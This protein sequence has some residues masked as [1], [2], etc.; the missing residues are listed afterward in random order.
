MNLASCRRQQGGMSILWRSTKHSDLEVVEFCQRECSLHCHLRLCC[1]LSFHHTIYLFVPPSFSFLHAVA[2]FSHNI[3][4][5]TL[6]AV[7][8]FLNQSS[9][10]R[11]TCLISMKAIKIK[12]GK[13]LTM[14][15]P[16][17][18]TNSTTIVC[19]WM[20]IVHCVKAGLSLYWRPES[21]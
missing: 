16:T 12:R 8:I 10:Q 3:S 20:S 15:A 21:N 9:G 17:F 7:L 14:L 13:P 6:T 2:L 5:C 4:Q 1:V 18:F 19:A 11:W